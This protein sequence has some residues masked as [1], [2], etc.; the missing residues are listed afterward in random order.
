MR[1]LI[2]SLVIA[3]IASAMFA[4]AAPW[5]V[6]QRIVQEKVRAWTADFT[7][8][9]LQIDGRIDLQ[10]L[11]Y[12]R[13]VIDD[14]TFR[15]R[16]EHIDLGTIEADRL[17]L[18]LELSQLFFGRL[19]IRDAHLVRPHFTLDAAAKDLA[20]SLMDLLDS[21]GR[22]SA[23]HIRIADGKMTFGAQ[24]AEISNVNAAMTLNPETGQSD[25]AFDGD[26]NGAKLSLRSQFGAVAPGQPTSLQLT[27][28]AVIDD[29]TSLALFRG[30]FAPRSDNS[31]LSGSFNVGIE[32]LQA[33]IVWWE[34]KFSIGELD[35]EK[36]SEVA[37][38]GDLELS[39]DR[40]AIDQATATIEDQVIL[41]QVEIDIGE[42]PQFSADIQTDSL[43]V[44]PSNVSLSKFSAA[45][46]SMPI[47]WR[48][49]LTARVEELRWR[50]A[51]LGQARLAAQLREN[52]NLDIDELRIGMPGGGTAQFEGV[53]S[54]D[55]HGPA[56]SGQADLSTREIR[57]LLT[58]VG[59]NASSLSPD[60]RHVGLKADITLDPDGLNAREVEIRVD[61]ARATGDLLLRQKPTPELTANLD[62]DRI[63]MDR[64]FSS[65]LTG[66]DLMSG[67]RSIAEFESDIDV[68]LRRLSWKNRR[69]D[70]LSLVV[71]GRNRIFEVEQGRIG[72]FSGATASIA[73]R[74]E[75]DKDSYLLATKI[76]ITS[77]LRSIRLAID[78][79][80]PVAA[81][82]GPI[83][84]AGSVH[85]TP[86]A[87]D[88]ELAF[89][90]S[91]YGGTLVATSDRLIEPDSTQ[92]EI[93]IASEDVDQVLRELESLTQAEPLLGGAANVDIR[94]T[95]SDSALE[96]I[97]VDGHIG[98]VS[99]AIDLQRSQGPST[100]LGGTIEIA[101]ISG[102]LSSMV[103]QWLLPSS[104]DAEQ[105]RF[106]TMANWFEN[107]SGWEQLAQATCRNIVHASTEDGQP[108][109]FE[110]QRQPDQ[111]TLENLA[112]PIADGRLTGNAKITMLPDDSKSMEFAMDIA[113]QD[114]ELDALVGYSDHAA[115]ATGA[116]ALD[117]AW[118]GTGSTIAETVRSSEGFGSLAISNL[119]IDT[120][121]EP[122]SLL[123]GA[124]VVDKGVVYGDIKE[125]TP[126]SGQSE[127]HLRV[128]MDLPDWSLEASLTNDSE[129]THFWTGP[130]DNLE[131]IT[132]PNG[133]LSNQ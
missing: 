4:M 49:T 95:A 130:L 102:G 67:L 108:I 32:D 117:L 98:Q 113:L 45:L 60:I 76:D 39:N 91:S 58:A 10:I 24:Q 129:T 59:V 121:S 111:L 20:A 77:P 29:S 104:I 57:H 41:G 83:A 51:R 54:V 21:D 115:P 75:P 15:A 86:S 36:A 116:L 101:P 3:A 89:E 38:E 123:S 53:L 47:G 48:G 6:D 125:A 133:N 9:Q 62:V 56:L 74:I 19:E 5:L 88:V 69:L 16:G 99:M 66:S 50:N 87:V 106:S 82:I 31:V 81:L 114:A 119:T 35:P 27:V 92:A 109:A 118:A 61:A 34:P 85:G 8:G 70:D 7:S 1:T 14:P 30:T 52:G 100:C 23:R 122:I 78:T 26:F 11:P 37:L 25:I 105:N 93:S 43:T 126:H 112:I 18:D 28:T 33:A 12:P 13:L 103:Q 124:I 55:D 73:G 17:D 46:P 120:Q 64:L 132:P 2:I 128:V 96:A 127:R 97:S 44:S 72:E 42:D 68:R 65:P 80:P 71:K 84:V 40:I 94:L 22:I 79:P 90:G 110:L 63:Q 107:S 131:A